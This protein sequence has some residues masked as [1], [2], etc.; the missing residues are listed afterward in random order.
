MPTVFPLKRSEAAAEGAEESSAMSDKG[1][2]SLG[3][4]HLAFIE[5]D[6]EL[7]ERT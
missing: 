1:T 3:S 7:F 2:I 4:G 5:E 6:S